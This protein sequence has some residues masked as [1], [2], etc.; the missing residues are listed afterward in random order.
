VTGFEFYYEYDSVDFEIPFIGTEDISWR[1]LAGFACKSVTQLSNA[2]D[3]Y[4]ALIPGRYTITFDP[5]DYDLLADVCRLLPFGSGR[6]ACLQSAQNT[7][8]V[9]ATVSFS[10]EVD[11]DHPWEASGIEVDVQPGNSNVNIVP[12]L[13]I[14]LDQNITDYCRIE[15]IIGGFMYY[16]K[17]I[18]P[19]SFG[20]IETGGYSSSRRFKIK[21]V[22]GATR[23]PYIRFVNHPILLR[24]FSSFHSLRS[25]SEYFPAADSALTGHEISYDNLSAGLVDIFLDD[26]PVGVERVSDGE[27]FNEGRDLSCDG[28]TEYMFRENSILSGSA[29]RLRSNLVE[30]DIDSIVVSPGETYFEYKLSTDDSWTKGNSEIALGTMIDDAEVE[31]DIRAYIQLQAAT[32][33]N[34]VCGQL[35]VYDGDYYDSIIFTVYVVEGDNQPLVLRV[36]AITQDILDK[37]NE[38][39][40]YIS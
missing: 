33:M 11:T 6:D 13:A 39:G 3:G 12:G 25:I 2:Q 26:F 4:Q 7:S 20:L 19:C 5:S 23:T 28:T 22:S 35:Q 9:L 34:L 38:F 36:S 30:T 32:D 15:V 10:E 37:M 18:K 8:P 24:D 40:V 27:V 16:D 29:F 14:E 31:I 17:V 21:N 1:N